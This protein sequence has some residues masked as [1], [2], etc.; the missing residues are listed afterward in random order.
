MVIPSEEKSVKAFEFSID[1][2]LFGETVADAL[3]ASAQV[4]MPMIIFYD[5]ADSGFD[6][7]NTLQVSSQ[8][9]PVLEVDARKSDTKLPLDDPKLLE[10]ILE[11]ASEEASEKI[12]EQMLP[13]L[14]EKLMP[15]TDGPTF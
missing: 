11:A 13:E 12:F 2:H 15:G 6:Y 14:L 9:L 7:A 1:R 3:L 10:S 4:E 5:L 8:L